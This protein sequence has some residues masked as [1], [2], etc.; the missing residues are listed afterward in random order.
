LTAGDSAGE[1]AVVKPVLAESE[2]A[3]GNVSSTTAGFLES[4]SDVG[5]GLR[6][7]G[8]RLRLER[9]DGRLRTLAVV[10]SVQ[11]EGKTS[12]AL[13]LAAAFARVGGKVLLID[14][15]LRRRDVC[16]SLGIE[17]T[18]GL[19][20]WLEGS[21][22]PVPVRRVATGSFYVLAAGLDQCR[23]EQLGS[24]RMP[25]LLTAAEHSFDPVILDCAP[26]LPVADSLELRDS[27]AGF[28][29][30]VRARFTPR[31]AVRR[32]ASLL[33]REKLVG[34]VLNAESSSLSKR[35]RYT[36]G[37]GYKTR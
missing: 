7:V 22:E 31:R 24:P 9:K 14:A 2:V 6:A 20:E 37:Y 10:S 12:V 27:V 30:V 29:M 13:G 28:L 21:L 36:Y 23:P 34:M 4:E 35:R 33:Q 25:L 18:R 15:D 32:A 8:T 17:P 11:G 19:A 5:E 3:S 1:A 26:L 16:R